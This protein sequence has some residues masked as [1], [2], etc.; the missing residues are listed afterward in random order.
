MPFLEFEFPPSVADAVV[1]DPE[2]DCVPVVFEPDD[3][4]LVADV[5]FPVSD[6]VFAVVVAEF[7]VV[8][9]VLLLSCL[10]MMALRSEKSGHGQACVSAEKD[11]MVAMS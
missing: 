10:L 2:A 11:A 7:D 3:F 9:S 6:E 1:P 4:V 8:G 5:D